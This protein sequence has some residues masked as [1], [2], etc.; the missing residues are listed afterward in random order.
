MPS[1]LRVIEWN[2]R[3]AR[4]FGRSFIVRHVAAARGQPVHSWHLTGI[5]QVSVRLGTTDIQVFRQIFQWRE[6]DM[7]KW[8]Q[9]PRV[10][11]RYDHILALDR[12]PVIVDAGANIGA[13]ALWFA[14]EF[15]AARVVAVEPDPANAAACRR[16]IAANPN[17]KLVEAAIGSRPGRIQLENPAGQA[18]A[19][20]TARTDGAGG[21][22]VVTI[23]ELVASVPNAALL[24]AKVDIEGFESDLFATN[25]DWLDDAAAILIETH[26]WMLPG[27]GTSF[28]L[29]KAMG[30]R[31]FEMVLSGENLI[32]FNTDPTLIGPTLDASM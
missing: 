17:I 28:A 15:P 26:D 1:L 7:S 19:P 12:V 6:Y 22:D 30:E 9:Y 13:S 14:N 10:R 21:I 25:I 2:L 29:Q 23:P 32:Y 24:L 8:K 18:W 20:R 27:N 11:A 16:N 3:D 4:T 31:R 5:G